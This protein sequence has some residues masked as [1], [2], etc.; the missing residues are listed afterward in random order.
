[1]S[2]VNLQLAETVIIK[3]DPPAGRPAVPPRQTPSART[4]VH[5]NVNQI[6]KK[7]TSLWLLSEETFILSGWLR[8]LKEK[9]TAAPMTGKVAFANQRRP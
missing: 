6:R 3:S 2:A 1:M 7:G 9:L 8:V 4:K 5:I